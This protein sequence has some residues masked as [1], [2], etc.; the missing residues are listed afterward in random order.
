[1]RRDL[2]QPLHAF[3]G[4]QSK[5]R[6]LLFADLVFLLR[7]ADG[8]H[9]RRAGERRDRELSRLRKK[10][11]ETIEGAVH[12]KRRAPTLF[13]RRRRA[14]GSVAGKTAGRAAGDGRLRGAGRGGFTGL[15][16][17][18]EGDAR[19]PVRR[20]QRPAGFSRAPSKRP[21][22]TAHLV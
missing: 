7:R 19:R 9:P 17:L 16:L 15:L 18:A 4:D 2:S 10:A 5:G 14:A 6:R 20:P 11:A 8:R 1:S 3:D 21:R 13:S 22:Q 12:A